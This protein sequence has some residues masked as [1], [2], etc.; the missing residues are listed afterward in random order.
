MEQLE[1]AIQEIKKEMPGL[2][3]HENEPMSSHCSFRIGGPVRALA[4]PQEL[5]DARLELRRAAPRQQLAR[6]LL[7]QIQGR[8]GGGRPQ[9]S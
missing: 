3:L 2:E 6:E 8:R 7:R 4:A 1:L 9:R 5:L